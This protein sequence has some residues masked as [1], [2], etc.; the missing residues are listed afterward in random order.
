MTP[1]F[2][3]PPTRS[4][5]KAEIVRHLTFTLA[6]DAGSASVYDWRMALSYAIRDRI[7]EPWFASTRR[8]WAEDR[9]RVYYLSMEFLIG[10]ILEDAT[11]NLG[12]RDLAEQAMADLGQ[13]FRA[14][15]EDE[16]DAA[17][18]NGGLGRLAAC[19]ME[20]MATLGCPAYGY[21]IRYEHGLFRQ[22]FEGGQQVETPEDWLM[23]RHPWEF[24]RPEAAYTIGFKGTVETRDGR[25]V[26]VPG[27]TVIAS[28]HDTPVVGWQGKWANTLRLWGAKPTTL[29]DLVRFNRGDYAAAAEPEALARTLSRVLY[30]DDTTYQ[31]KELRLKQEYFLTSAALQDILRRYTARHSDLRALPKHVAIQMND[32][33]PAIAGPELIR[34]LVDDHGLGFTEALETARECLG[35]TNHTLLPEALERWATFTFGNVLP[36][37]MQI[38]EQID[39]WHRRTYP[40][41]PHYV[42]IVKH[43]EVRMGELAFIMSHK[44]N[45][46]SGLHS[47]LIKKNLF[48]ELNQLHPGRIIN[49]TNGVTP[50]RWLKMC[51]R[52]LSA[53]ITDTIGDGWED[54]LDRLRG[55]EP[56]VDDA[57]F[58]A[59][60]MAAK[61]H[62]KEAITGWIADQCGVTVSPDA[63]FDVQIKRIHEYKRQLLNILETIAHWQAIKADPSGP[64]VPRVK[65]FGGKSAPGYF[66]AKE[67]IHFINDVGA[68]LNADPET[69]DLLTVIYPPNYN[70]S[71]AERLIPAADLSEQISTAGK[72]ASGTG[73][74]KFMMNG[75]PTIG[76][77]DGANVEILH[78]VGAENF[79]LFGLTAEEVTKRRADPEHARRAIEDSPVLQNVLQTIAEGRFSPGQADRYHGLVHRVWHEDYFL[80]ASDFDAYH[81]AQKAVSAAFAD[82]VKWAHMAAM[83]TARSGFFSSD[84]TIRGYMADVWAAEAAL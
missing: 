64:W 82:P 37:H 8:T 26:W 29:F 62:N 84:R 5:L 13:D 52:P 56:H 18:G 47:E 77:L 11:I 14:I 16:P 60:F 69:R 31:G 73:N 76:T 83:N 53:L 6:K 38:V 15:V 24:D 34:L 30:P 55:L 67:I 72:E 20:S 63:M 41:R 2:D 68:V 80:V 81:G 45:G 61:R 35:Y 7:V 33:H 71:M 65:I 57:G 49:E 66:V 12:L 50:R 78:E 21:G 48:P 25:A 32:T 43:H 58:R 4:D 17:L 9:K 51:N 74:M 3:T 23:M 40:A 70:V 79:F 44:V 1:L 75:A 10:R 19:F 36:R 46:V 27:E 59:E 28:A 54:D 22:R 42:G 39:S